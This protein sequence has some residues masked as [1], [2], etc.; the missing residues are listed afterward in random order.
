MQIKETEYPISTSQVTTQ[1][2]DFLNITSSDNNAL[3]LNKP[4]VQDIYN[5]EADKMALIKE[6][7]FSP[8]LRSLIITILLWGSLTFLTIQILKKKREGI[9]P[10][11]F[12]LYWIVTG[13]MVIL[14]CVECSYAATGQFVENNMNPTEIRNHLDYLKA[15]DGSLCFHIT[16]SHYETR[17]RRVYYTDSQGRSRS[18]E[19][20]YREMV[21]THTASKDLI[22]KRCKDRTGKIDIKFEKITR[23]QLNTT[24]NFANSKSRAVYAAQKTRFK[25]ANNFDTYQKLHEDFDIPGIL[26]RVLVIPLG[27]S[28]P[29]WMS[30][31]MYELVSLVGLSY[32]YRLWLQKKTQGK[33]IYIVKTFHC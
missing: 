5:Q 15:T 11:N 33:D 28:V 3:R 2:R 6:K 10:P 14:Y 30:A 21:V 25:S 18:R 1:S 22:F 9:E 29:C 16:C 13:L 19:Q 31:R 4:L 8:H 32:F 17:R 7:E 12:P 24:Y 23:L 26:Q 20:A 27:A